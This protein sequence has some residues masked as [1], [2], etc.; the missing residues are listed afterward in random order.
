MRLSQKASAHFDTTGAPGLHL[1]PDP[2]ERPPSTAAQRSELDILLRRSPGAER[3]SRRA[4]GRPRPAGPSQAAFP[5]R[6]PALWRRDSTGPPRAA[7]S[8][9]PKTGRFVTHP[10]RLEVIHQVPRPP[11]R[12]RSMH[13]R[14]AA[15]SV[16]PKTSRR[17]GPLPGRF[18]QMF[19]T[20][21][22]DIWWPGGNGLVF[23]AS[24]AKGDR[25]HPR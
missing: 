18:G 14:V 22:R 23:S 6:P 8:V 10:E 24:A 25:A 19:S 13:L 16:R 3:A 21:F 1:H 12:D 7:T 15:Q 20:P 2:E 11:S 5:R 9:G 4:R 17:G